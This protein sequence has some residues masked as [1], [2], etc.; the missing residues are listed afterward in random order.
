M[1][2]IDW[3][4]FS[5][6]CRKEHEKVKNQLREVDMLIQ[7]TSS[8]VE[9]LVQKNAR[10]VARQRQVEAQFDTVPRDDIKSTYSELVENQQRLFTMRGQLEKLQSDQKHLGLLVELYEKI[11]GQEDAPE[12]MSNGGGALIPEVGQTS[13]VLVVGIIEAQERE[14]QRLSRQMH[15]G[16]AQSLTNLVLQAEICERLFDRNPDRAKVE[17]AELK[18]N[19]VSTF[20]KVRGFIF[21]LRPMM[22]DDLGLM[23]TLK[24]YV[25]GLEE[26]GFTGVT[27]NLTGKEKRLATYKEVTIF[28]V[29]QEL[30]HISREH[31]RAM[32]IKVAMDMGEEHVR[33][34]MED[35]GVGL[36]LDPDLKTD[37]A[38]RL[39]L[40]TLRERIEML[41]GKF[42]ADSGPGQG[43]HVTF[44]IPVSGDEP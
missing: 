31:D 28:R 4:Q 32:N 34:S 38:V 39:G 40:S 17:L 10:A 42:A 12:Q 36:E 33:V 16:P 13:Q 2:Q 22:L 1:A 3:K 30:L 6:F 35:N 25:E 9:H 7:Q 29:L 19:V 27:L 14:R 24:R 21:E 20:Q 11:L 44:S 37:D 43:L 5:E 18:K 26:S 15:D 23:P 8:E 41:G